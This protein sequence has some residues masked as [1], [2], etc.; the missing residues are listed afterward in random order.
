[1]H[2]YVYIHVKSSID[3]YLFD[4][5]VQDVANETYLFDQYVQRNLYN[6]LLFVGYSHVNCGSIQYAIL[7]WYR[8]EIVDRYLYI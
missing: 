6:D 4:Q 1:M 2:F 8:C 7:R 5:H 3:T